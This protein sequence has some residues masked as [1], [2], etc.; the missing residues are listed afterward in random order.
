MADFHAPGTGGST[1]PA[2]AFLME[3]ARIEWA[4][5]D[6]DAGITGVWFDPSEAVVTVMDAEG[7]HRHGPFPYDT[8]RRRLV[9]ELVQPAGLAEPE[10][11]RPGDVHPGLTG[12]WRHQW[13]ELLWGLGQF[14]YALRDMD[15]RPL[16]RYQSVHVGHDHAVDV[17]VVDV[18]GQRWITRLALDPVASDVT[19]AAFDV[20]TWILGG[21]GERLEDGSRFLELT[22]DQPRR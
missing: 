7:S 8:T 10:A 9:A 13:V 11:G 22:W 3:L 16:L 2:G 17:C 6:L 20:T 15:P 12:P 1:P 18:H 5:R 21:R 4:S 19:G 14:A